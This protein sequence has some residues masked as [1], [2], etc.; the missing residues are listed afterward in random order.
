MQQGSNNPDY[1]LLTGGTTAIQ[2]LENQIV[3]IIITEY[4]EL[5]WQVLALVTEL[6][7]LSHPCCIDRMLGKSPLS[8]KTNTNVWLMDIT[9][10]VDQ[11]LWMYILGNCLHHVY[12]L[13]YLLPCFQNWNY[14]YHSILYFVPEHCDFWVKKRTITATGST[15]QRSNSKTASSCVSTPITTVTVTVGSLQ[16]VGL[17]RVLSLQQG[18]NKTFPPVLLPILLTDTQAW[19]LEQSNSCIKYLL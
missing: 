7:C 11:C 10:F 17:C 13:P 19:H 16:T 2:V 12:F 8:N 14:I 18:Q 3:T 1:K 6:W 5:M 15:Y 4:L 9:V